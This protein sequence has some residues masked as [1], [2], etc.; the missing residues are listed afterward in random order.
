MYIMIGDW[1][2]LKMCKG[3]GWYIGFKKYAVYYFMFLN[4]K[5]VNSTKK[6]QMTEKNLE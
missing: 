3:I 2:F 6:N 1:Q 5:I 4:K